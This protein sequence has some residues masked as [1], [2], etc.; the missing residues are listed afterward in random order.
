MGLNKT[1]I[2]LRR[3]LY[4][5]PNQQNPSKL[6]HYVATSRELLEQLKKD[7]ASDGLPSISKVNLNEYSE[8]IEALAAALASMRPNDVVQAEVHELKESGDIQPEETLPRP[9]PSQMNKP[10][11]QTLRR[12]FVS[13]S[14]GDA[15]VSVSNSSAR[16]D[17]SAQ[18]HIEKHRKLQEDLTDEMVVLARQLKESS[19]LMS[20]SVKETE[21]ILDSTE[22]AVEHSLASTG[23]ANT[24]AMEVY[25]RS[26]NTTCFTW[27]LIFVMSCVFVMVVLLIRVT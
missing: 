26:F 4:F 10:S 1:E 18:E 20:Q 19:L 22:K 21:K 7:S 8:R 9:E 25:S 2:N 13:N 5:A 6:V 27:L 11:S 23:H 14:E 17:S 24:R 15:K 3:L 12:R 16:L